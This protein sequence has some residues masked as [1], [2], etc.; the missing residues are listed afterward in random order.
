MNVDRNA[1]PRGRW[2]VW[3]VAVVAT[4]AVAGALG[5]AGATVLRPAE[6]P[7]QATSFTMV[8]VE[9][10]EVGSSLS[11]NTI[12]VWEPTPVGANQAAGIVTA[13]EVTAGDEAAQGSVLYYVNQRPVVVAAGT[14]PAF[15]AIGEGA[16]G[17]DVEQLQQMLTA[18][19]FYAGDVDGQVRWGT[20]VAI[21]E[22]QRSLGLEQTGIVELGDVIFV[23]TLPTRVSLDTDVI[24][25]DRAVTGGEQVVRALPATP[26][27]TVPVTDAQAAM[28]PAG[29]VVEI[30]APEG[31][32]WTAVAA[33]QVRDEQSQTVII[34]LT[35]TDDGPIC[36]DQCSQ[37]PVATQ[38]RLPSQI[39]TVPTVE[40]LVVPSAA[41]VTDAGGQVA[42][43]DSAGTRM[44]VSVVASARGV[45]VIEGID[46][47]TSVRV[48]AVEGP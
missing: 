34:S 3:P 26:V 32:I 24:A 30:T 47:G 18:T 29:T 14:V 33:D 39:V 45:S 25:R 36:A 2:W 17:A 10:G 41:L 6:D 8:S 31:Q 40:G 4:A 23:P 27:F 11:L 9:P 19:G 5:W 46:Q 13:V 28:V 7:L 22:W 20:I 37:I 38:S 1:A 21:R 12:A 16:H 44:Q 43:I 35:G 42:V 48:P 15:R